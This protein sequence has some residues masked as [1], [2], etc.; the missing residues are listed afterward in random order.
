M[1]TLRE[2][3]KSPFLVGNDAVTLV[4]GVAVMMEMVGLVG[5]DGTSFTRDII[6]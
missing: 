2:A 6:T 4:G 1:E 3:V 5:R